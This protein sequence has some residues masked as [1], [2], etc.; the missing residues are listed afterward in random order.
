[1]R[2]HKGQAQLCALFHIYESTGEFYNTSFIIKICFL[3][4]ALF[5][6]VTKL[7]NADGSSELELLRRWSLLLH[8]M[9]NL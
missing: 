3:D 4:S 6:I 2:L 8:V 7:H 9:S 5:V 1:M